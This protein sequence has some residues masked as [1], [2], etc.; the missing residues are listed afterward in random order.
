M[1]S[2][3]DELTKSVPRHVITMVLKKDKEKNLRSSQR[4]YITYWG[5]A[6]WMTC[7]SHQKPWRPT[8]SETACFKALKGKNF[9]L[10]SP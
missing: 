5:R 7:F 9:S 3:Q 1:N 6:V 4:K 8:G 10:F 2:R